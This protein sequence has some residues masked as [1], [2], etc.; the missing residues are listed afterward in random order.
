MGL[1]FCGFVVILMGQA[2][3]LHIRKLQLVLVLLFVLTCMIFCGV[4]NCFLTTPLQL[5]TNLAPVSVLI[6]NKD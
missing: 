3:S 4:L 1:W 2:G 6:L 5:Q